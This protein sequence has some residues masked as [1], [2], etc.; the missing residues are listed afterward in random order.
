MGISAWVSGI[1]G[2]L[3]AVMGIIIALAI[4]PEVAALTWVFWFVLSIILLLICIAFAV[5]STSVE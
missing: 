4:I 3:C 1:L 2:G 5:G